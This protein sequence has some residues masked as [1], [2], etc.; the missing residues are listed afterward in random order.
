MLVSF[1]S[2]E[3]VA[4]RYCAPRDRLRSRGALSVRDDFRDYRFFR[5]TDPSR[6]THAIR[7]PA[8]ACF[9]QVG[10]FDAQLDFVVEEIR[11]VQPDDVVERGR[12]AST[13]AK[14]LELFP[15]D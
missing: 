11:R 2:R 7:T 4:M 13:R 3:S 10:R 6:A 5:S 9:R 8:E 14:P 15:P 12:V 1:C